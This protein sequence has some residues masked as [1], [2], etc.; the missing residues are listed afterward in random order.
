MDWYAGNLEN[1]QFYTFPVANLALRGCQNTGAEGGEWS[2]AASSS[3][4]PFDLAR[5]RLAEPTMLNG[6]LPNK[7]RVE[8]DE[9]VKD[10]TWEASTQELAKT[11]EEASV[12]MIEDENGWRV[13]AGHYSL[14]T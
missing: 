12:V 13:V 10:Q 4:S 2:G 7:N 8:A 3:P 14:A 6:S 9:V 1:A 5:C 11:L